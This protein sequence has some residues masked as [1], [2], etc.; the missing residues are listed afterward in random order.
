MAHAM[1]AAAAVGTAAGAGGS[2]LVVRAGVPAGKV[3]CD[4]KT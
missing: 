2:Q 4:S 1:D 3:C